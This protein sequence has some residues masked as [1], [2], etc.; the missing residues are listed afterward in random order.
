VVK[1]IRKIPQNWV[2]EKRLKR[3]EQYGTRD[4]QKKKGLLVKRGLGGTLLDTSP[5]YSDGPRVI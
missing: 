1:G 2:Q 5:D 3:G 4:N